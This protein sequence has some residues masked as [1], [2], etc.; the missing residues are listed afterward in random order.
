MHL[1]SIRP[2]NKGS[3]IFGLISTNYS[4]IVSHVWKA[5]LCI[6]LFLIMTILQP[7]FHMDKHFLEIIIEY[8]TKSEFTSYI[9][10]SHRLTN[11][12]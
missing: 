10:N 12:I 1:M 11:R 3:A 6:F 9:F 5:T 8:F 2:F 7:I 4:D